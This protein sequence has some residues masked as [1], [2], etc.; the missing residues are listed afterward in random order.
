MIFYVTVFLTL[1][2][3]NLSNLMFGLRVCEVDYAGYNDQNYP[4]YND[5]LRI[6]TI[7]I[8]LVYFIVSHVMESIITKVFGYNDEGTTDDK[9]KD[10]VLKN[11]TDK[12][13]EKEKDTVI[14]LLLRPSI[15]MTS[16]MRSHDENEHDGE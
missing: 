14:P 9:V 12:E 8:F 11:D 1:P 15:A 16:K 10:K 6:T 3:A 4:P 13:L 2:A 5:G 7:F